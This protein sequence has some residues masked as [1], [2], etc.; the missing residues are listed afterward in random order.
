MDGAYRLLGEFFC[1]PVWYSSHNILQSLVKGLWNVEGV[2]QEPA[3]C[4]IGFWTL[5]IFHLPICKLSIMCS[6]LINAHYQSSETSIEHES[7]VWT[8]TSSSDIVFNILASRYIWC[9]KRWHSLGSRNSSACLIRSRTSS[10]RS[11][12]PSMTVT[13]FVR[14]LVEVVDVKRMSEW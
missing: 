4:Q 1:R 6:Y 5:G 3:G 7:D 9:S 12:I 13:I 10:S 14:S 8:V 11:C 2:V